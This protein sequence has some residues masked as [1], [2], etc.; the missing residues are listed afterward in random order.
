MPWTPQD[1]RRFTKKASGSKDYS[2]EWSDIA[3]QKLASGVDEGTAIKVANGVL[4]KRI[5]SRAVPKVSKV[6]TS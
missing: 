1:A 5:P 4:K 2:K 3:N 6:A